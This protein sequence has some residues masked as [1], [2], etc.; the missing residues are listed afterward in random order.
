MSILYL[1]S[2]SL[3]LQ[4]YLYFCLSLSLFPSLFCLLEKKKRWS[5][6]TRNFESHWKAMSEE[7]KLHQGNKQLPHLSDLKLYSSFFTHPSCSLWA[8]RMAGYPG[9]IWNIATAMLREKESSRGPLTASK[10]TYPGR[11]KHQ[12]SLLLTTL[13]QDSLHDPFPWKS[14][15]VQSSQWPGEGRIGSLCHIALL[16]PSKAQ[17]EGI[18]WKEV[19]TALSTG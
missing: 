9:T 13:A 16:T 12:T 6:K 3:S 7:A 11:G 17:L 19:S 15:E 8:V 2:P 1:P 18:W 10:M 5:L 4:L 14:Q